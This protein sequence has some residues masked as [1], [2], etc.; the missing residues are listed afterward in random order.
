MV[1]SFIRWVLTSFFS[2]QDEKKIKSYF[3]GLRQPGSVVNNFTIS[4]ALWGEFDLFKFRSHFRE[5]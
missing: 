5:K 2:S 4:Q 3:T 1:P